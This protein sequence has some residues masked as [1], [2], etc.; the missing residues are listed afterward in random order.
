VIQAWTTGDNTKRDLARAERV[1]AGKAWSPATGFSECAALRDTLK[2]I[3]RKG[4]V[5]ELE[6][7]R[8]RVRAV[9]R[10]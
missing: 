10:P 7:T 1:Q 2:S 6:E 3:Q 9:V 5:G 4:E 8:E